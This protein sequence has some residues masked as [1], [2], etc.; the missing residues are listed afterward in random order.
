MRLGG[1]GAGL[2]T[3]WQNRFDERSLPTTDGGSIPKIRH[4]KP[5]DELNWVKRARN[6]QVVGKGSAC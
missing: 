4:M 3:F 1:A 5:D 2:E 6:Q